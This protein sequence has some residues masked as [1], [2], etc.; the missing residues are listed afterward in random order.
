MRGGV[1][2]ERKWGVGANA[3]PVTTSGDE[4]MKGPADHGARGRRWEDWEA[5][6]TNGNMTSMT[7]RSYG[8]PTP[9]EI[10]A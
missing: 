5:K 3:M 9:R 6:N 10:S 1:V 4:S 8:S 7:K 2:A